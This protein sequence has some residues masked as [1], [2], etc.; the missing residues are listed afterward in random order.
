LIAAALKSER[1]AYGSATPAG[2]FTLALV[3]V[4]MWLGLALVGGLHPTKSRWMALVLFSC[5]LAVSTYQAIAGAKSC[6]CFGRLSTAPAFV[7]VF[8]L[9]A[10]VGLVFWRPA[11]VI[12][13]GERY[14]GFAIVVLLSGAGVL[15]VSNAAARFNPVL[16]SPSPVDLGTVRPDS[17]HRVVLQLHNSSSV[18]VTVSRFETS[19]HCL[20]P[21]QH[22]CVVGPRQDC[23]AGFELDLTKEPDFRGRL[24]IRVEAFSEENKLAFFT[25]VDLDVVDP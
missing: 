11:R 15:V 16:D 18:P 1:I 17:R 13:S 25:S 8:D 9:G 6:A 21:D 20:A 3:A 22:Q 5:F 2:P 23:A 4:E 12:R 7:A 14:A 10:L 19:C 24:N